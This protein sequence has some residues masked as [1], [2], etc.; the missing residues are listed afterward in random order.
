MIMDNISNFSIDDDNSTHV[1]VSS[2]L[3]ISWLTILTTTFYSIIC[4]LGI[5]G[6]V[7]VICVILLYTKMKTVTNIYILNLAIADLTFLIGIPFLIVTSIVQKWIF[8][9]IMCKVFWFSSSINWFASIFLLT[10][11]SADRYVAVCHPHRA[12]SCRTIFHCVIVCIVVWCMALLVMLPII[13]YTNLLEENGTSSCTI[14]WP[15]SP[16][17]PPGTAFIWYSMFLG[18]G[19]PLPM[20]CIFYFL[21]IMR[22]SSTGS[23]LNNKSQKMRQRKVTIMILA[24]IGMYIICW[25]PYWIHQVTM[26]LLDVENIPRWM[27]RIFPF[28]MV[29]SYTN[30]AVNP[31]LYAFLSDSFRQTFYS[32]MRCSSISKVNK[33]LKVLEH[34]AATR[35]VIHVPLVVQKDLNKEMQTQEALLCGENQQ[36]NNGNCKQI[37]DDT[38][39]LLPVE[40]DD[41][42]LTNTKDL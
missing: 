37:P 10:V 21:L 39:I 7:M 26:C 6:N 4:L 42:K 8:G 13:I 34:T 9:F 5:T 35:G 2:T 24:V 38:N 32:A 18:F 28:I 19:I 23:L 25:M 40:E 14:I 33:N 16:V 30:S 31:I 3:S 17:F 36:C 41:A 20:I 1:T 11:M 29:F 27:Y 15:D 22:L 12:Q